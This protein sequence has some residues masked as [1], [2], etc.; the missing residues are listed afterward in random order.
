MRT[1]F[2]P[3]VVQHKDPMPDLDKIAMNRISTLQ[4]FPIADCAITMKN[5]QTILR[6]AGQQ[7]HAKTFQHLNWQ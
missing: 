2:I 6:S 7:N 4:G 5:L 1:T 3:L